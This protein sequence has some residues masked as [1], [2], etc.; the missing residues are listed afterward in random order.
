MNSEQ[1]IKFIN[2][3][4]L[5]QKAEA[6]DL[7]RVVEEYPYS[8]ILQALYLKALKNQ[9]NYLYPKQLKRTAIAVP[10]RRILHD[11]VEMEAEPAVE[12]IKKPAIEF[13][14]QEE[15]PVKIE[16]KKVEKPPV[17]TPKVPE[18]IKVTPPKVAVAK[19]ISPP[20]K[21]DPVKEDDLDLSNLPA[22]IRETVLR[23]RKLR[24]QYGQEEEKVKPAGIPKPIEELAEVQPPVE[25]VPAKEKDEQKPVEVST[26]NVAEEKV[27]EPV[28]ESVHVEPEIIPDS[29]AIEPEEAE[30]QEPAFELAAD[31]S[32]EEAP[33][34]DSQRAVSPGEKH[35]F[36]EW[37]D[38]GKATVE[39]AV[40][41]EKEL[42]ELTFEPDLT[43][44]EKEKAST[45][46]MKELYESFMEKPKIKFKA[47]SSEPKITAANL[48]TSSDSDYITETLAQV[49]VNQ[50]LYNRAI[51]AYEILSLKYPEKSSFFARQISEIKE[52]LNEKD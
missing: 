27:V 34:V 35:S 13:A 1:I 25:P 51:N 28:V 32:I 26:P 21:K 18:P 45:E 24:R 16:S 52:F 31:E 5:L 14:V 47:P 15:I 36:L 2:H 22:S 11:W 50:K 6:D 33:Q 4:E 38:S 10:N 46:K 17:P 41:E 48:S 40:E 3:P 8:G 43:P 29:I 20:V 44:E 19:P 12:Q 37:L 23:A 9:N 30:E 49:Y 7:Q 39:E 42:P